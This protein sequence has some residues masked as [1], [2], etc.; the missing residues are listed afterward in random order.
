[1]KVHNLTVAILAGGDSSRFGSYKAMADYRGKPLLAHMIKI[2]KRLSSDVMIVV[3]NPTQEHMVEELNPDINVVTDPEG[4]P[5]SALY[6]AVTAFEYASSDYT[7]LLPADSPKANT[8]LLITLAQM[9]EGHGAVVPSWPNGYVEPLHSVYLSEHAY[10][11]G[12]K[13]LDSESL[14][15]QNLL[16]LLRNVIYVSTE[17]L[18]QFDPKLETFDNVNSPS[19]LRRLK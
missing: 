12:L 13:A 11:N 2:G 3:S 6:G 7:L 16:S 14:K 17:V 15:M 9:K 18:K 5:R 10:V 4:G 19:D 1:M 8:D